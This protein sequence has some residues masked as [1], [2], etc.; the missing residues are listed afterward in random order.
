MEPCCTGMA[1]RG[2]RTRSNA[3]GS[4]NDARLPPR[5]DVP[6][7]RGRDPALSG[8]L[9]S[10]SRAYLPASRGARANDNDEDARESATDLVDVPAAVV[11]LVCGEL[12]CPGCED[13]DLSRSGIVAIVAWERPAMPT[14][15]RL[16]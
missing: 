13:R 12:D 2:R 7:Q 3:G 5:R 8:A 9:S 6:T 1:Q 4:A 10:P 11:C 14:L 15:A 16:W